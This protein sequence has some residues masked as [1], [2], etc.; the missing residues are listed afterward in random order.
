M[1]CLCCGE[2]TYLLILSALPSVMELC[3]VRRDGRSSPENNSSNAVGRIAS[4]ALNFFKKCDE[5]TEQ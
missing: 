3:G 1:V 5:Q 4:K 2:S